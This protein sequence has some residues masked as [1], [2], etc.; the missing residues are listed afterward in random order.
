[1]ARSRVSGDGNLPDVS[2]AVGQKVDGLLRED[3]L[4]DFSVV[5]IDFKHQRLVLVHSKKPVMVL[6]SRPTLQETNA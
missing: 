5:E 3:L 4:K 2:S 1:M 6:E